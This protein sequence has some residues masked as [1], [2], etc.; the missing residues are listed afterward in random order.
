V[1]TYL[2][3]LTVS[4]S[5]WVYLLLALA[6]AQTF[7]CPTGDDPLKICSTLTGAPAQP[8]DFEAG[9]PLAAGS[10]HDEVHDK[11]P[12]QVSMTARVVARAAVVTRQKVCDALMS[13]PCAILTG[14]SAGVAAGSVVQ[15]GAL[16]IATYAVEL[17][18]ERGFV[19][20]LGT[21]LYQFLQGVSEQ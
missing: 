21:L 9:Q 14:Q 6:G 13:A 10:P 17:L 3:F 5:I 16:T 7:A 12:A 2:V 8:A 1:N 18:L 4:S 19:F 11:A 15:I 20:A